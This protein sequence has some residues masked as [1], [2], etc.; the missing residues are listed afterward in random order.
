[1]N[2]TNN[3]S[4]VNDGVAEWY[5]TP[6]PLYASISLAIKDYPKISGALIPPIL[7]IVIE[8]L[9]NYDV[10]KSILFFGER[11]WNQLFSNVFGNVP[12]PPPI[13]EEIEMSFNKDSPFF[14]GEKT[15]ANSMLVYVPEK[16]EDLDLTVSKMIQMS[17]V[18]LGE[19][20]VSSEASEEI[21]KELG[22]KCEKSHW[23]L[24]STKSIQSTLTFFSQLKLIDSK[25]WKYPTFRELLICSFASYALGKKWIVNDKIICQEKATRKLSH[26]YIGPRPVN[27]QLDFSSTTLEHAL[28]P[29]TINH[30]GKQ[31]K[32]YSVLPALR[33]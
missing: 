2:S 4:T 21:I 23:V 12:P 20:I 10:E 14:E 33:A 9:Q 7:N 13:S 11:N 31:T 25:S 29:T 1:M 18:C 3:L 8:Y 27:F 5:F 24:I 32:L 19:T 15:K 22:N 28:E 30:R 6:K 26:I 16:I 17:R